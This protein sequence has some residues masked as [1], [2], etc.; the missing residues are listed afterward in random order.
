MMFQELNA[1]NQ[2]PSMSQKMIIKQQLIN[3]PV[4]R[5]WWQWTTSDG[6][7]TFFGADNKMELDIGGPYEIYF[8]MDIPEGKRG[9]EGCKVLSFIPNKMISFSWNAPPEYPKI[10]NGGYNPWVVVEFDQQGENATLVTLTH[11]GYKTGG[12]WDKVYDYFIPAWDA[13]MKW[14]VDSNLKQEN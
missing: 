1:Q 4:E 10:R 7:K 3:A 2:K 13:V 9:S 12:N 8:S 6:L 11:L 5:V 14:L